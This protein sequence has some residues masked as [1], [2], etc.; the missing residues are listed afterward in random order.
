M[1]KLAALLTIVGTGVLAFTLSASAQS[2]EQKSSIGTCRLEY[3]QWFPSESAKGEPEIVLARDIF[4]QNAS[5]YTLELNNRAKELIA[6]STSAD[7]NPV[8][9]N[10]MFERLGES[11]LLAVGMRYAAYLTVNPSTMRPKSG[12]SEMDDLRILEKATAGCQS[13]PCRI[14]SDLKPFGPN[15]Q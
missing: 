15:G 6:C 4:E 10:R 14:Y 2:P 5:L 8:G 3:A 1:R 9:I 13:T 11:Y 7:E 12:K